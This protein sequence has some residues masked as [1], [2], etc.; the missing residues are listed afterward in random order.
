MPRMTRGKNKFREIAPKASEKK[1]EPQLTKEL[2]VMMHENWRNNRKSGGGYV[3]RMKTTTD[4][5]WVGAHDGQS[6]V[7]IASTPFDQ[8][9]AD[10][11]E[12]N[13]TSA[14]IALEKLRDVLC[15]IHDCWLDRNSATASLEQQLRYSKLPPKEKAKDLDILEEAVAV[16]K[17]HL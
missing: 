2:A 10:R 12:E 14:K 9:P 6:E 7:D 4:K 13:L 8:L 3:P 17:K 5:T 16:L 15:L 1:D 11:K